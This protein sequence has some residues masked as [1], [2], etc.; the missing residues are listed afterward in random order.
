M[1]Q[2][3][4]STTRRGFLHRAAHAVIGVTACGGLFALPGCGSGQSTATKAT[5]AVKLTV[6]W[7]T[8]A[9][10]YIPAAANSVVA[11]VTQSGSTVVTKTL[12]IVRPQTTATLTSVPSGLVTLTA[13]AYAS[14]D[15]T[16]SALAKATVANLKVEAGK[17]TELQTLTLVDCEPVVGVW[18]SGRYNLTLSGDGTYAISGAV[19]TSGTWD[20]YSYTK[21]NYVYKIWFDGSDQTAG[22]VYITSGVYYLSL[23]RG[24]M[25]VGTFKRAD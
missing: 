18:T 11:K 4:D 14:T 16:G 5:G 1:Q 12:T 8:G 19:T 25:F 24:D 13:A 7:P 22:F 2:G 17:T 23:Y 20:A 6:T 10:R 21:D 3:N 9:G 15:G